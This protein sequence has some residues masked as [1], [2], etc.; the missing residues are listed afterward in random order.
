[1]SVTTEDV[2]VV[3]EHFKFPFKLHQYQLQAV[4]DSVNMIQG[5]VRNLHPLNKAKVGEGKTVMS[6]YLALYCSI[7]MDVEQILVIMPPSLIDQWEEFLLSIE[8]IPGVLVY[9]GTIEE[10]MG[11]D[12]STHS[13]VLVSDRIFIRQKD[14][15]RFEKMGKEHKLFIIGDELSLKTSSVTYKSWKRLI[16]RRLK[17]TGGIHKPYHYFCGLNATPVSGRGQVYWWCS[18]FNPSAYISLK[19]FKRL[20]VDAEDEWGTPLSFMNLQLMDK[21]FDAFSIEPK[22]TNIQMPEQ[23]F[24]RIPYTLE[25]KHSKMYDAL[26]AAEFEQFDPS[27]I[28]S[29]DALFSILQRAVLV[30]SEFGLDIRPPILDIIDR[31]LDQTDDGDK[32]IVYTRHVVVSK[33][34]LNVYGD[35]AVGAFGAISRS[36][37]QDNIKRFKAGEA[38]MV[39]ANLDSLSKGQNLQV[40]NH[41]I[42]AELP[43]RSDVMTQAC[44]RTARQGQQKDTCFFYLPVAKGTIQ[45]Q[46]C[47]NLLNNDMDLRRFNNNPKT[48]M[49]YLNIEP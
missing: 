34:L 15:T 28:G 39:I 48:L 17:V 10:R 3:E 18:L 26:L 31:I 7:K 45:V 40:A 21:N 19:T 29:V 22:D 4:A 38:E 16:F 35:R 1:M 8:G 9:R 49:E 46:I 27:V 41:T 2:L 36:K 24:T 5:S 32:I 23:V 43:F 14:F 11:M 33:M 20:H 12:L 47:R 6:L 25:K 30:P 44:G 42:F 13:V 37:K